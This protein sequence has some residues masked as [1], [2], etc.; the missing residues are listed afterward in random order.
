MITLILSKLNVQCITHVL[1]TYLRE[2]K[3][4]SNIWSKKTN[5]IS[6]YEENCRKIKMYLFYVKSE[7]CKYNIRA[8]KARSNFLIIY[9]IMKITCYK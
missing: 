2:I 7:K 3:C 1:T 9:I 4:K 6:A 8:S 5:K